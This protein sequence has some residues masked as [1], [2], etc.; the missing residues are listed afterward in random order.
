MG[1]IPELLQ[2][3]MG[4]DLSILRARPSLGWAKKILIILGQ[5]ILP[6]TIPMGKSGLIFWDCLGPSAY[7]IV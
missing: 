4:L 1:G 6:M 3:W 7:F 2:P 5:K